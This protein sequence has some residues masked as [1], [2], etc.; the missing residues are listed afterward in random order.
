MQK[1]ECLIYGGT[2]DL[3]TTVFQI[4]EQIIGIE[5]IVPFQDG[6]E[7]FEAFGSDAVITVFEILPEYVVRVC[8]DLRRGLLF[9]AP[10]QFLS[11]FVCHCY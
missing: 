1:I 2:G 3:R 7:H 5:V 4:D 8:H 9:R 6:I 11:R 10:S